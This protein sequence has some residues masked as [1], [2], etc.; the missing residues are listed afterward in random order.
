MAAFWPAG[1]E[2]M[3]TQSKWRILDQ[4]FQD[5]GEAFEGAV[6]GGAGDGLFGLTRLGKKD[7]PAGKGEAIFLGNL[8]EVAAAADF[9]L[10]HEHVR[11]LDR[12][13]DGMVL[14]GA[15]GMMMET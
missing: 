15:F 9:G 10:A 8:D 4:T 14:V 11:N 5:A 1:P 12:S 2:P 3:T 7:A 6:E 13:D